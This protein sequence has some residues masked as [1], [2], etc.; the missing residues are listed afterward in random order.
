M[1]KAII[2]EVREL[3][4][5]ERELLLKDDTLQDDIMRYVYDTESIYIDDMLNYIAPYLYDYSIAPYDYSY[6]K[7]SDE[8]GF[9]YGVNKLH[10]DYG[11]LRDVIIRKQLK[12]AIKVADDYSSADVGSDDYYDALDYMSLHISDIS[13]YLINEFV[14][15]LEHYDSFEKVFMES[16]YV[17]YYLEDIHNIEC[18]VDNDSVTLI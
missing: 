3:N 10:N 8:A 13:S 5:R 14:S 4:E 18:L 7:V 2:K 17:T 11:V 1:R 12:L 15:I 16:D 6:M 9:I